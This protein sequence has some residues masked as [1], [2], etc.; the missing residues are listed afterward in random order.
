MSVKAALI[1]STL[2]GSLGVGGIEI[3]N[4][5]STPSFIDI[6]LKLAIFILTAR[7]PIIEILNSRKQKTNEKILPKK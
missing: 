4:H 5:I 7:K 1:D 3:V 6:V 2:R